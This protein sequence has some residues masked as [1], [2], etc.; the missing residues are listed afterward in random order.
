MN[1]LTRA[2]GVLAAVAAATFPVSGIAM[3]SPNTQAPSPPQPGHGSGGGGFGG[4]SFG[5]GGGPFGGGLSPRQQQPVQPPVQAPPPVEAPPPVHQP[6]PAPVEQAPAPPVHQQPVQQEQEEPAPPVHKPDPQ[7]QQPAPAHGPQQQQP[8]TGGTQTDGP[9]PPRNG[10]STDPVPGQHAGSD[11]QTDGPM[12]RAGGSTTDPHTGS[13]PPNAPVPAHTGPG[14]QTDGPLPRVGG[15]TPTGGSPGPQAP[16]NALQPA[17]SEPGQQTTVI[18]RN[19]GTQQVPIAASPRGVEASSH[20]AVEA[21]RNAPPSK[22]DALSPPPVQVDFNHQAEHAIRTNV[23]HDESFVRPRHWDYIDY[24]EYHRPRL[25]NPTDSEMSFKYFYGGDYRTVVVPV[26]GNV[27]L[28]AAIAG[29]YPITVIAGDV[30]SAA[31]FIGG[32]FI[33]PD[34]WVGPPPDDWAPY[35]PVVYDS[36]PVDFVNA[37]DQT[38]MVDRVTLVG[39]DDS[40]PEGQRDVFTINDSTLARGQVAPA[41]DGGP[42]QVKV[43]QTQPLPGVSPWNDGKQYVNTQVT[44]LAAAHRNLAPWIVGGLGVVLAALAGIAGWVWKHPRGAHAVSADAPTEWYGGIDDGQWRR[45]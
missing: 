26:G 41:P 11:I 8:A 12:P 10:G 29:V 31:S 7:Q 32:A 24:D 43:Q 39:H 22:V 36:V 45:P 33:P 37:D 38:A 17:H 23:D 14:A 5:G 3:A 4:G 20:E 2:V 28:D 21:A 44:P 9:M 42:P 16:R 15:Q 30:I 18:N 13:T 25:F 34:G 35:Q 1:K 40:L 27:V 19:G 6:A